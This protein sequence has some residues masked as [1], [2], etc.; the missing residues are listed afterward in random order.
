MR[1]DH[2]LQALIN[3]M[4]GDATLSGLYG[5]AIRKRGTHKFTVPSLDY[6]VVTTSKSELWV[7]T[8]VQFNQWTR[9]MT[10]LATSDRRLEQ[11]FDHDDMVT[12]E[13]VTM[14]AQYEDG[15]DLVGPETEGFYGIASR[16]RFTPIRE[17]LLLGRGI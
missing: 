2:I 10:D 16:Y 15:G 5:S 7:P 3:R 4:Q 6:F 17:K 1:W 8:I 11:L 9:S 13:G 14:W 12:I